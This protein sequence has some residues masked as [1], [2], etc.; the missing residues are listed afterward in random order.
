MVL[1][2]WTNEN[3]EDLLLSFSKDE[4]LLNEKA[5]KYFFN[6]K[7]AMILID[8]QNQRFAISPISKNQKDLNLFSNRQKY[9]LFLSKNK[10]KIK[11]S[12]LIEQLQHDLNVVLD[13]N[14]SSVFNEMDNMLI[15]DLKRKED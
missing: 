9:K 1:F 13:E 4:I 14:Y 10:I 5:S 2:D 6:Y 11:D 7:W 8:D 12:K 15:I 3:N